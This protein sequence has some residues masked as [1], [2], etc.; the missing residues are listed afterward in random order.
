MSPVVHFELP[1][2]DNKK[3]AKF[4]KT[5]FG[6]EGQQSGKE[7]G[8]YIVVMTTPST[9]KGPKRPGAINGGIY[10]ITKDMPQQHP[11]FVLSVE[12][13]KTAIKAIEKAGGKVLDKPMMIPGVGEFA[14]FVDPD[15][16][17]LSILQPMGM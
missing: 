17:R 5:V 16:N 6:W 13:I 9:K 7:M 8:Y 2:K 3:L 10:N 4:Y 14:S 1:A 12:N 11:S 15:G